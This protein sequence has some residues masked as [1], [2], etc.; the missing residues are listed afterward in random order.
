MLLKNLVTITCGSCGN[1]KSYPR[2]KIP[3]RCEFC[4]EP[5]ERG[6]FGRDWMERASG[7]AT[8][9]GAV[10]IGVQASNIWL[11]SPLVP[12][13]S[14]IFIWQFIINIVVFS[15]IC[16]AIVG[17]AAYAGA[18]KLIFIKRHMGLILFV[19]FLI[20]SVISIP[21]TYAILGTSS[22]L[23]NVLVALEI[24]IVSDFAFFLL[25]EVLIKRRFQFLVDEK[26]RESTPPTSSRS[27]S[28][29][30]P[31]MEILEQLNSLFR[32]Q[33]KNNSERH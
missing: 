12:N 17:I 22:I 25:I 21:I 11:L 32:G 28:N 7:T 19:F 27:T 5:F 30:S 1:S 2:L 26:S 15:L 20:S 24:N 31:E 9:V 8:V 18:S 10:T 33:S 4:G 3:A 29:T 13:I 16:S 14:Q 6:E 23:G